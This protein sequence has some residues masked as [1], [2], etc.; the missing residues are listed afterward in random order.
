MSNSSL[1]YLLDTNAC[2]VYLKNKNSNINLHLDSVGSNKIAVCSVV[3]AELFYGSMRSNNP[4][5][6]LNIQLLFLN[7]FISL[8][9]DDRCAEI[10]GTIRADL[11][12]KGT[13]ISLN[14][15]Q[16]ASIALANNLILVINIGAKSNTVTN[17]HLDKIKEFW[18]TLPP[19]D[20]QKAIAHFLDY[21]TK[22][23]DDLIAKKE[24]LIEK[25]DEK[26]TALIS[27]A[28]TKGLEP[29][30]PMKNSGIE[31]LDEIPEHWKR[32]PFRWC[33]YITEGQVDPTQPKFK[34]LPLIAPNHIESQTGKLVAKE[35]A[36]DQGAIS[37]KYF[38]K[39][40]TLLYSK[41]RPALVKA[42]ISEEDGLCSADMYPIKTAGILSNKFMLYQIL[43]K[44]FTQLAILVSDR[45]AMPKVN[46]ETLGGFP[47]LVPPLK[48]Q[49]QIV[50]YL[51]EQTA[52]IT[53]QKAKIQQA[54]ER[55]KEYRT[56]LITNAVTGKIDVRQVPIP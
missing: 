42:C 3:K 20:E 51:D 36:E 14:D 35:T 17:L 6:S 24:A 27:H 50:D 10:Y 16:I 28:V 54:I 12:N 49:Q 29:N 5:K 40:G 39:S 31:W 13:P 45:V 30:A 55:L 33:C 23:I 38:Y 41:I 43:S 8:P 7:Q 46:R 44:N 9:F 48:E 25:L 22:Q 18:A 19:L 21:K 37:G 53:Q 11:A 15:L 1:I 52:S 4:Q 56:A 34:D 26:R 47:I 2:I 32:I